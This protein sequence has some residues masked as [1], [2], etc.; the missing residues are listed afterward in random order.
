MD[1]VNQEVSKEATI[2]VSFEDGKLIFIAEYEGLGGGAAV[3]MF[4]NAEYVL[5]KIA[6]VI[7]G[8][9]DDAVLFAIKAAL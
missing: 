4:G 6:D 7:P 1:L 5:D 8:K 3:K 2:K 9:I